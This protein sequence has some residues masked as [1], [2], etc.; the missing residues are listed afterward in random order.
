MVSGGEDGNV[1]FFDVE[2]GVLVNKLQGHSSP[3]LCI[4]WT[5]DESFL[6]SCDADVSE[7]SKQLVSGVGQN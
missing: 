7:Q 3:A 5:Y 4:C 6:A 2:S 1:Y